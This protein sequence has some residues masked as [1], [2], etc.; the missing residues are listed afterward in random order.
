MI[1]IS[2]KI[3]RLPRFS[4]KYVSALNK[5]GIKTVEDF[6]FHFPFRYEDYSERTEI[7]DLAKDQTVTV[8]GQ[9]TQSKLVRTWKKRMMI[10]ECH[11]ADETGSVRA[12]W[13]NQP[14]VSDSLLVGKGVRLSGKVSQDQNGFFFS[15]PSWELS[16]REPTNTGR[17][18]PIYPETE[19]LTSRWIRWQLQNIFKAEFQIQDPIPLEILNELHLP[20]IKTALKYIHFPKT[21]AESLLAQK[22]FAFQIMLT[23]QLTSLKIKKS[24][25]KEKAQKIN[26]DK[27]EIE[28]FKS[29]LPFSL[30]GAQQKAIGEILTDLKKNMPMNRLLNGDVGSGKTIV[31]ATASLASVQAG[32]QTAIMAPTEVLALQHFLTISKLLNNYDLNVAL[33]TN[34]YAEIFRGHSGLDPESRNAKDSSINTEILNQVQDDT[35]AKPTSKSKNKENLLQSLVEGKID[36]LIGTHALIQEKIK[37]KNLTL[38]IIDEQHRF[39]VNQRAYLQQKITEIND[40]LPGKIPHL[41][42]MTATPIPRTLTLAFFGNLDLSILDEMPKNRKVIETQIIPNSQREGVY[43]FVRA[44]IS[45]GR[46]AF[47][48]LPLVEESKVLTELKDA[49]QEH[50]RLSKKIFPGMKIGLLHGKLKSKEKEEVMEKFK[51]KKFDI[52]VATSVVEVGIDVPNSTIMIIEDSDR[53]GLSQLHQ[54]RGRVGRGEHQSYCFL[55]TSSKSIKSKDRLQALVKNSDGFSIA[56]K[57]LE[58]RGPG[59]FFGARQS[60]IPDT[61]MKHLGNVKL[62]EI[63]KKY[64]TEILAVDSQLRKHPLLQKELEKFSQGVHLE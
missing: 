11:I 60:G 29:S 62:I 7:E 6:L 12:V 28:K 49:T 24:W 1:D 63:A 44:Q 10:T 31:A 5:L 34:S 36:I 4:E 51:N 33:L 26:F 43:D 16:S 13:F 9:I 27:I 19:G 58:L 52:L 21:E 54:F 46:Q 35:L 53:F 56:E 42:T 39:G 30:T 32:F 22:R 47:V 40:G 37:F 41:L 18:V 55:F 14:Y 17:L 3:E 64:A 23:V 59:E 38:I 50:E 57:D 61:A 2:Q 48:I 20:E 8:M 45:Q 15:N 25:E